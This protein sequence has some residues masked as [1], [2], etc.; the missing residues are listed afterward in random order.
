MGMVKE[1]A[2]AASQAKDSELL[3]RLKSTFGQNTAAG[4]LFDTLRDR[5]S[6]T[7]GV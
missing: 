5:L 6:L 4:A 7:G 3:G 1:A 2:E